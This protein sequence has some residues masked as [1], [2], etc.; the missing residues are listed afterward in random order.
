MGD[1]MNGGMALRIAG[2]VAASV[3]LSVA[4]SSSAGGQSDLR[5]SA[6][7]IV[8]TVGEWMEV[9][10]ISHETCRAAYSG[11]DMSAVEYINQYIDRR[12]LSGE[13]GTLLRSLCL[14]YGRGWVDGF[15]EARR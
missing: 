10:D 14:S 2:G 11:G 3:G 5:T 1:G 9:S 12:G 6:A 7:P 13:Q 4:S 8:L 15:D